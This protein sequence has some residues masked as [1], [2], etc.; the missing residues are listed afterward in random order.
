MILAGS[1][2]E[3]DMP[4]EGEEGMV[5]GKPRASAVEPCDQV[6]CPQREDLQVASA[7]PAAGRISASKSPGSRWAY[8]KCYLS[9]LPEASFAVSLPCP[10]DY[11]YRIILSCPR[12]GSYAV[13]RHVK[14]EWSMDRLVSEYLDASQTGL[15]E[16]RRRGRCAIAYG[17]MTDREETPW[18]AA[19]AR[20]TG[21][22]EKRLVDVRDRIVSDVRR[23]PTAG[24]LDSRPEELYERL[25][26]M[27]GMVVDADD[28]GG[29]KGV[30]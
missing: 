12:F 29:S 28:M 16:V 6:A 23:Q 1:G 5:V 26:S 19:L 11:D 8:G 10:I 21:L 18:A 13:S 20:I 30:M 9:Q 14:D 25:H 3:F 4:G 15:I 2:A 17:E 27:S 22:A 24:I 7:K